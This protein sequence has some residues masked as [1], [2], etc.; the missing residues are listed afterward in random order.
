MKWL[1]FTLLW[2]LDDKFPCPGDFLLLSATLLEKE[3]TDP[4][5]LDS[6]RH[7][8][9]SQPCLGPEGKGWFPHKIPPNQAVSL[10]QQPGL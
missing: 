3:L 7:H 9:L 10:P 2:G 1:R 5:S 6:G 4:C 8:E